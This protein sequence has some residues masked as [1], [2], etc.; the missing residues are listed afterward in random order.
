MQDH[1]PRNGICRSLARSV[2]PGLTSQ[3]AAAGPGDGGCSRLGSCR[4]C[5]LIIHSFHPRSGIW[6]YHGLLSTS[7]GRATWM[8]SLLATQASLCDLG[9]VW[10]QAPGSL[11]VPMR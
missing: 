6:L 7:M 10:S 9:G 2:H 4:L 3:Q 1:T 8:L 11:E 5:G